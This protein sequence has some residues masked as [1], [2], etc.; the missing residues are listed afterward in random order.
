MRD[1]WFH[2]DLGAVLG[3]EGI[4]LDHEMWDANEAAGAEDEQYLN[5]LWD[6]D[7]GEDQSHNGQMML[8]DVYD[9]IV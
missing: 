8:D 9:R 7:L 6:E 3:Q 2:D 1:W 4:H 5:L